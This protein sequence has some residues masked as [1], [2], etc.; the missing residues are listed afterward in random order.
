MTVVALHSSIAGSFDACDFSTKPNTVCAPL[1]V[2][3]QSGMRRLEQ[4]LEEERVKERLAE[5][6]T[7]MA[8]AEGSGA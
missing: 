4:V 7:E 1:L 6:S 2:G 3:L 8:L 5:L